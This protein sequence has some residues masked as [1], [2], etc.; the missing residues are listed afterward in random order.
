MIK[1]PYPGKLFV[2]EGID[3]CGKSTQMKL[4]FNFVKAG[5]EKVIQ[6]KEPDKDFPTGTLIYGLLFGKHGPKFSNMTQIERQRYYFIDRM[7]HYSRVVIPALREG[8]NVISDRS[9]VSVC[10]D[11]INPG[12]L[13]MLLADE[14]EIFDMGGV[15]FIRPDAAVIYDVT[16]ETSLK[17]H[18]A[19]HQETD[20]FESDKRDRE[21][22]RK[23]YL[24]FA[25]KFSDWTYV[26]DGNGGEQE[27]FVATREML[28]RY[29]KLP[30]WQ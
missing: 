23:A 27:V 12:D 13:E 19:K 21:Q 16:V 9:L 11:V 14:E 2:C 30:D 18:K 6:T 5:G 4:A 20:Y 17:R 25:Q 1:N 7:V 29:F 26:V 22:Q 10:L 3:S 24:E 28:R 8:I 15:E